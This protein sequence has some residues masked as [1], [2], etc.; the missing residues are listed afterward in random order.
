MF[1][2]FLHKSADKPSRPIELYSMSADQ[3][4]EYIRDVLYPNMR[5]ELEDWVTDNVEQ[6]DVEKSKP[7]RDNLELIPVDFRVSLRQS[8]CHT[9][10]LAWLAQQLPGTVTLISDL[11]GKYRVDISHIGST[12]A[13]SVRVFRKYLESKD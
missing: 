11:N 3:Y 2:K 10:F 8:F 5:R 12:Y 4:N 1:G 6:W 9:P 13:S 7:F